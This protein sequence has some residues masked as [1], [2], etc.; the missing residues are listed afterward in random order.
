M[1]QTRTPRR[2]AIADDSPAFLAA[3][4]GYVASLPGCM[5]VG[6]AS[7]A[8]EALELV[9]SVSPDLLLLDLGVA[10]IRGLEMVRRIK[11]APKP[12]VVIALALFHTQETA[13]QAQ[14]AGA[15][16][17]IGKEAFVAGLAEILPRLIAPRAA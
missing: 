1:P 2:I 13:V 8:V 14:S 5:L 7:S 17:L 16:A 6:T 12:P 10:P 15:D 4:A 3:A 11:A 9:A